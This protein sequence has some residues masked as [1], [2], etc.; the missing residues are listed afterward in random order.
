MKS[1][2]QVQLAAEIDN[3]SKSIRA[4]ADAL[5]DN[6]STLEANELQ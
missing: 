1:M 5:K 4:Q 2:S 6:Q 3:A